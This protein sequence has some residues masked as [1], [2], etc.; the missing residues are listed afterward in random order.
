M[1][2]RYLEM[3][4]A[5]EARTLSGVKDGASECDGELTPCGV[6]FDL[7]YSIINMIN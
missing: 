4:G 3:F 6:I 1:N 5:L 2:L 7:N